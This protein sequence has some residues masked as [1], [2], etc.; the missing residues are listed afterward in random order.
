MAPDLLVGLLQNLSVEVA[1]VAQEV[2]FGRF[3]HVLLYVVDHRWGEDQLGLIEL[4]E[5]RVLLQSLDALR[6]VLTPHILQ[7]R[8]LDATREATK[9][10]EQVDVLRVGLLDE[11]D[12]HLGGHIQR[13]DILHNLLDRLVIFAQDQI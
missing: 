13:H 2:L 12:A 1:D 8:L 7:L 4:E 10:V 6:G 11:L 5:L 3:V 9:E